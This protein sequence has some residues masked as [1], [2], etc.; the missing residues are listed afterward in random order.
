MDPEELRGKA[1]GKRPEYLA[2]GLELYNNREAFCEFL[3]MHQ[4]KKQTELAEILGVNQ[5]RISNVFSAYGAAKLPH[6]WFVP[7]C[8]WSVI[9]QAM[10]LCGLYQESQDLFTALT[11]RVVKNGNME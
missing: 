2:K 5:A 8:G 4:G 11:G 6:G 1:S 9:M 7:Y 10:D 3:R